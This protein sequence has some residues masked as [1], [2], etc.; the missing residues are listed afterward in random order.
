MWGQPKPTKQQ[1]SAKHLPNQTPF[2]KYA[3]VKLDH[4]TPG[5][6]GSHETTKMFKTT[7]QVLWPVDFHGFQQP[8]TLWQ[9]A[10]SMATQV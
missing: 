3:I 1:K 9:P 8:M 2:E 6:D 7:N 5:K 4:E 10:T